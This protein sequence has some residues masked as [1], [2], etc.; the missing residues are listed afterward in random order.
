MSK[1]CGIIPK[2]RTHVQWEYKEKKKKK[3]QKK[4]VN[5]W[6]FPKMKR[7]KN[8]HTG[9]SVNT[10]QEI[11]QEIY[12]KNKYSK[13]PKGNTPS[14]G[15][16]GLELY[17]TFLQK[18]AEELNSYSTLYVCR[19]VKGSTFLAEKRRGMWKIGY[20]CLML[21]SRKEHWKIRLETKTG[22]INLI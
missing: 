14:K 4:Y 12:F 5:G 8:T 3:R 10:K 1:T 16:E 9:T 21:E 11:Y 2:V 7:H 17:Q 6:E 13:K 19:E 18:W 22:S 15:E 20:G